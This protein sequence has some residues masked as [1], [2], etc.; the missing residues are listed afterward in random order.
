M[1][2]LTLLA[3]VLLLSA[4]A[5]AGRIRT[6]VLKVDPQCDVEK[7]DW[8]EVRAWAWKIEGCSGPLYCEDRAGGTIMECG[9]TV[10]PTPEE[11]R[12][13][14]AARIASCP[15]E[16]VTETRR[17]IAPMDPDAQRWPWRELF[18]ETCANGVMVECGERDSKDLCEMPSD[19]GVAKAQLALESGCPEAQMAPEARQAFVRRSWNP[20]LQAIEFQTSWRIGACGS[21]YVCTATGGVTASVQCKA[22]LGGPATTPPAPPPSQP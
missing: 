17:V 11:R 3:V 16:T 20:K 22:A 8:N 14:W 10:P 12:R 13:Q 6:A 21:S 5:R 1:R 2:N 9:P 4:C 7:I 18:E 19:W 15:W